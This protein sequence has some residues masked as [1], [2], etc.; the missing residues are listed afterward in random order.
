MIY[1]PLIILSLIY[2]LTGLNFFSTKI[3]TKI[4]NYLNQ[5]SE[6]SAHASDINF[7]PT[8]QTVDPKLAENSSVLINSKEYILEDLETGKVLYSKKDSTQVPIASTTKIMTA[9][10]ALEN[11]NLDDVVTVP[12]KA[13]EQIPT[14]V[15]LR[16]GE[17]ITVSELLHCLLIK[18]GNDSAYTIGSFMDKSENPD[19]KIF[20]DA[21]NKK[22]TEL[23][24]DSTKYMD[25]AGLDDT[26][27][28]SASDL[29]IITR[30]ALKNPLFRQIVTTENYVAK[31]T[32]KTIFH[33]LENS[34][35]LVT[36]YD[37]PGAIGVK[38]GFTYEASHCLV[39]AAER[40]GHGLIA[41]I[42]GTYADTP[43]AS[44]DEAKK[45]LDFGFA[46]VSWK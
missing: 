30:Y 7:Q 42:L 38:T 35:R 27:R 20:V 8:F 6:R 12:K 2:S 10:I 1:N 46:N 25:P 45:L 40:N 21:M 15:N 26:G 33:S 18:S 23:G 39:A 37:Y 43:N 14:V 36:T 9:V 5:E 11:Y 22:A 44:A 3:D 16:T 34:N 41:I 4:A 28:S 32:T 24:M 17:K 29:A 19:I 31:N 13:T